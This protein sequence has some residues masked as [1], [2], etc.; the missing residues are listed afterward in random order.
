MI[1]LD[2]ETLDA[3]ISQG[4]NRREI[5]DYHHLEEYLTKEHRISSIPEFESKNGTDFIIIRVNN[6]YYHEEIETE[7]NPVHDLE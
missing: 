1:I 7:S 3:V 4:N 6:I 2:K 5:G